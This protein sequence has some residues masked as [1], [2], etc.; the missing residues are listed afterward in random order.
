MSYVD[1]L[2]KSYARFVQI[3]W[4]KSLAG[5]QRVW[6]AVYPP[7]QE[8]RFRIR[9]GDFE[10]ATRQAGHGWRRIDWLLPIGQPGPHPVPRGRPSALANPLPPCLSWRNRHKVMKWLRQAPTRHTEVEPT[11]P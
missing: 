8:R 2:L 4:D 11:S 9:V 10:I 3:P 1:D 7:E 5:P 6:M